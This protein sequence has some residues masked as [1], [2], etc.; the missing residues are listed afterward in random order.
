MKSSQTPIA[1]F[2]SG[3]GTTLQAL[4]DKQ[5][6]YRVALVVGNRPCN[7]LLRAERHGIPAL[8]TRDWEEIDKALCREGVQ[9]VVLAGYLAIV[10]ERV[11]TK[12]EGRI[13][14]THPSLLPKYGGKGMYGMRVH[15][16][17]VAAGE[18]ET[19]CT[20]HYVSAGVDTGEMIAQVRVAVRTDDTAETLAQRVQA[21]ER[22]L[23][24]EV[25][26]RLAGRSEAR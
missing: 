8:L 21:Q 24:P 20:V 13:I 18:T 7:G 16:A 9:L 5:G 25:V 12:W 19:G 14:N 2:V 26:E 15:E 11:C 23:L 22:M 6:A 4:I 3:E 17:V 1:V 10:P